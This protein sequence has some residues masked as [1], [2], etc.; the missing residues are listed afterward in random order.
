[1]EEGLPATDITG[2]HPSIIYEA[3]CGMIM[4][5]AAQDR[6]MLQVARGLFT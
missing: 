2:R 4:Y 1:M 3:L 5:D 6:L